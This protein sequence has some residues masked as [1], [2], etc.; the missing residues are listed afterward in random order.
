[1]AV[2]AVVNSTRHV[3]CTCFSYCSST[4]AYKHTNMSCVDTLVN[5]A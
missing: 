3:P 5:R 2:H 1:L 4:A